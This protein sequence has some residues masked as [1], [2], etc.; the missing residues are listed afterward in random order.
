[1]A[2]FV[3]EEIEY[4]PDD[5]YDDGPDPDAPPRSEGW[6]PTMESAFEYVPVDDVIEQE[7]VDLLLGCAAGEMVFCKPCD[8]VPFLAYNGSST[9]FCTMIEWTALPDREAAGASYLPW[10]ANYKVT[11]IRNGCKKVAS[12]M[13]FFHTSDDAIK[14]LQGGYKYDKSKDVWNVDETVSFKN[15]KRLTKETSLNAQMYAASVSIKTET[16]KIVKAE[17]RLTNIGVKKVMPGNAGK[18]IPSALKAVFPNL[19]IK[20]KNNKPQWLFLSI[21]NSVAGKEVPDFV[22][23]ESHHWLFYVKQKYQIKKFIA[24]F[25]DCW[26]K[27]QGAPNVVMNSIRAVLRESIWYL[28]VRIPG[29]ALL[30]AT[31][32]YVSKT[33]ADADSL[34][35][36]F[37]HR[38]VSYCSKKHTFYR[39]DCPGGNPELEHSVHTI[40]SHDYSQCNGW[41][42]NADADKLALMADVKGI[43]MPYDSSDMGYKV[44]YKWVLSLPGSTQFRLVASYGASPCLWLSQYDGADCLTYAKVRNSLGRAWASL[45]WMGLYNLSC[46]LGGGDA[47]AF[48]VVKPKSLA[49]MRVRD[50]TLV[51]YIDF[52]VSGKDAAKYKWESMDHGI[53][54]EDL[55]E[56]DIGAGGKR[57]AP[58][59][60]GPDPKRPGGGPGAT[61]APPEPKKTHPEPK[62]AAA[63]KSDGP[64]AAGPGSK[65]RAAA[66]DRME[67]ERI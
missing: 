48:C 19:C 22:S 14:R 53:E 16:T 29:E 47:I 46:C 20:D 61:P 30:A 4:A 15:T 52:V 37:P 8:W 10:F 54:P 40:K 1:M 18:G 21:G 39:P 34:W 45:G 36:W 63:G 12:G 2:D 65:R 43:V 24:N 11:E 64:R 59:A 38:M 57:P 55:R 42:F 3:E 56:E 58:T 31:L 5:E 41:F 32:D 6:G 49:T 44:L 23:S 67:E 9:E 13:R 17:G 62:R 33:G 35:G 25:S 51:R 27:L 26:L 28:G 50:I 60:G 7:L 66:S